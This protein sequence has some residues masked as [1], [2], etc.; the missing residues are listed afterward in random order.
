MASVRPL[1]ELESTPHASVF[2]N[3]EPKTI[4]LELEA[5]E[6]IPRHTHPGRGIVLYVLEGRLELRLDA[7]SYEL[8]ADDVARF[9]GDQD[10]SPRAIEDSTALIVLAKRADEG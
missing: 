7:E 6:E 8:T 9:D 2:P 1:A 5:G 10:I 3:R 4:R